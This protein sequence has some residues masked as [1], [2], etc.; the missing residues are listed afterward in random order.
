MHHVVDRSCCRIQAMASSGNQQLHE[1]NSSQRESFSESAKEQRERRL[2]RR[3]ETDR[4]RRA[5]ETAQQREELLAK[6]ES[7]TELGEQLEMLSKG[8]HVCNI[9][10]IGS[11]QNQLKLQLRWECRPSEFSEDR[12]AR[13]QSLSAYQRDRLAA[14]DREARL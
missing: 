5:A 8:K 14:E 12:E 1:S 10:V 6:G 9:G 7:E 3:R 13:L 4:A 11:P 2:Q